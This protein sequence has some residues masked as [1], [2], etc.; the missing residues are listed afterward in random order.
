M[1]VKLK[2][3]EETCQKEIWVFVQ[4]G[5]HPSQLRAGRGDCNIGYLNCLGNYLVHCL[6]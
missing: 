4:T 2:E 3:E 5:F 6:S 1:E